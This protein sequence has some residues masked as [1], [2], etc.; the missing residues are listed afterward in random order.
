MY[1]FLVVS[2]ILKTRQRAFEWTKEIIL[3]ES[4]LHVCPGNAKVYYNIA[5]LASDSGELKKSKLFYHKAI[6][7]VNFRFL[8]DIQIIYT[9]LSSDYIQNMKQHA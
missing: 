1:L 8:A 6:E 9:I 2:L 7:Y 5:R 3:Y 4:A